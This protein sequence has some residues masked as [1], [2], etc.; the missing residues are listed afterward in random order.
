VNS[1]Q[2]GVSPFSNLNFTP[3]VEPPTAT[4]GSAYW[5]LF[6]DDNL[7][8]RTNGGQAFLLK[9]DEPADLGLVAG[10][11]HY[12]GYLS[13]DEGV[14]THCYSGELDETQHLPDALDAKGLRSLFGRLDDAEL[15]LAGRAVQIVNWERTHRFCGRCGSP[16]EAMAGERAKRCPECG[17]SNYPRLSPAII[18]AITRQT[19]DGPLILLARNHRFPN[20][21]YSVVAG[22]VEPGESLEECAHREVFEEV[23]LRIRNLRYFGSQ[24]WPFP[25]SLMIGF[26]AEY[27]GGEIVPEEGEIAEARWFAPD[28]LPQVPPR[29]SIARRL[30]DW[31]ASE[32]GVDPA[33]VENW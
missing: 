7:V 26:T 28:D 1:S 25:N 5:L 6:Q 33:S 11:I 24:P 20:G 2:S 18:I 10:G 21:R 9:A 14:L 17:L 19:D 32:N 3:A 12:L 15:A 23:G 8:V 31:F 30:I 13:D 27:D 4:K 29:V 16:T 22:F